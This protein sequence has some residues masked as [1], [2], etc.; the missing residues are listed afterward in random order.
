MFKLIDPTGTLKLMPV[1]WRMKMTAL[2]RKL[3]AVLFLLLF[4]VFFNMTFCNAAQAGLKLKEEEA[5]FIK[6]HTVIRL[7]IEPNLC[8]SGFLTNTASIKA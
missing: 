1:L 4:A 8:R 5:A 6:K 3:A 7:G 2:L